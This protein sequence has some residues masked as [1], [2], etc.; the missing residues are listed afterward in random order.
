MTKPDLNPGSRKIT[1]RKPS[2]MGTTEYGLQDIF[3]RSFRLVDKD[4]FKRPHRTVAQTY[5]LPPEPPEPRSE[6]FSYFV[7]EAPRTPGVEMLTEM[8]IGIGVGRRGRC[9]R[10]LR[11][12][13]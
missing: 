2:A 10:D 9:P 12:A 6:G 3:N 5:Q 11:F 1:V 13:C 8:P 7:P 4:I